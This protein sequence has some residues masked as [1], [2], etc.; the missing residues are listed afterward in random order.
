[1]AKRTTQQALADLFGVPMSVGSI[2]QSEKTTTEV[3]AEPVQEARDYIEAQRVAHLDE[4]RWREGGKG[5]FGTQSK[6]GSRFVE[7]MMTVVATLRQQ[8]RSVLDFLTTAHKAALHGESA[9]SL[10]SANEQRSQTA[11]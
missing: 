2:S 4:T 3:L 5:S 11:A 8:K 10:L 1:L 7:S 6:D 9:P